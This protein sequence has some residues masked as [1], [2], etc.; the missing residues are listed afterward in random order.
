MKQQI[1]QIGCTPWTL[2]GLYDRLIVS[3]YENNYGAAVRDLNAIRAR[4]AE[5]DLAAAPAH[6]VRA[7]KRE[8]LTAMAAVALHELYFGNLG[9]DGSV[10]FTGSGDGTGLPTPIAMALE[11]D[12]GTSAAWQSEFIALAQALAGRSG[13]VVLSY[14]RADGRL[15]NQL[16]E[17]STQS[18]ID[19][20]PLL[21]LDM[22]EH[23]YQ[24]EFGANPAAYIAA[25]LRNVDWMAVATRLKQ[26]TDRL[27]PL[28]KLT[29][30]EI[31]VE[32]LTARRAAGE[33]MQLIDAR[34]RF[35]F[36]RSTDM[37]DGAIYRDPDRV[38]EWSSELAADEPVVV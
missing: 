20:A 22:Y 9:G 13:W 15:S 33:R 11:Q 6:D 10:L 35:S 4:L 3:H 2:N 29:T 7:L 34:P 30:D 23:A 5:L 14:G 18:A 37:I 1:A 25:F 32:E 21:V 19:A 12:F 36:S 16:I 26:A 24:A 38:Y 28:S 31:S 27:Q 8:E 17:D